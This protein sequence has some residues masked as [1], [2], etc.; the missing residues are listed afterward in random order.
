[1]TFG[2]MPQAAPTRVRICA[3][4][5]DEP[6]V[7]APHMASAER[8]FIEYRPLRRHPLFVQ[9]DTCAFR[10]DCTWSTVIDVPL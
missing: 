4:D 2:L 9:D 10:N 5:S 1:M 3:V 7:T 8:L 6:P